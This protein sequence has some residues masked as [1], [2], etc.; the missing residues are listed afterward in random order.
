MPGMLSVQLANLTRCSEE[1]QW[2]WVKAL[3]TKD[4]CVC[5]YLSV[6]RLDCGDERGDVS[7]RWLQNDSA[8]A[9]PGLMHT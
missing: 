3:D 2:S 9:W 8:C 6:N 5:F 4:V 7:Y 1:E